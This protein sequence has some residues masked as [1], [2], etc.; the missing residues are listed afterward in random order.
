M[1]KSLTYESGKGAIKDELN[2]GCN[3]PAKGHIYK[4]QNRLDKRCAYK[5]P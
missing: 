4:A 1:D 5:E 3:T 2:Y